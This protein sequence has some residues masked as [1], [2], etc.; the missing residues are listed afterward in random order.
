MYHEYRS[1]HLASCH[2]P[3]CPQH[4]LQIRVD[5][6]SDIERFM[7]KRLALGLAQ[8]EE[9]FCLGR[10]LCIVSPAEAKAL[11]DGVA[12][13]H[14][15]VCKKQTV[16]VA[17]PFNP[18][19]VQIYFDSFGHWTRNA[20]LVAR[21]TLT[22][23][24]G[25]L[26]L[27]NSPSPMTVGL[28]NTFVPVFLV[29]ITAILWRLGCRG[30]GS[31]LWVRLSKRNSVVH[32]FWFIFLYCS[33]TIAYLA[34]RLLRCV[35]LG[36]PPGSQVL[37]YDGTVKCFHAAHAP[38]AVAAI[39]LILIFV[40]PPPILLVWH[41]FHIYPTLKAIVDEASRPYETS[42][43]WWAAVNIMRRVLL[44]LVHGLVANGRFRHTTNAMIICSF[45]AAQGIFR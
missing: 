7:S 19:T 5:M 37:F 43:R 26:C 18:C 12:I 27:D 3:P 34:V 24:F 25:L 44:S 42:R 45:V 22:L 4:L 41:P 23:G 8:G 6:Y 14:I 1:M 38:Y 31:A 40:L 30:H 20:S 33:S 16:L 15:T 28:I 39:L 21:S 36:D 17:F 11:I 35:P 9:K 2:I 13:L 32:V 29:T 10:C